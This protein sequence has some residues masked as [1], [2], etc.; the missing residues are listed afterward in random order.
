MIN[1]YS[2]N[3][4]LP[5]SNK[6]RYAKDHI[7]LLIF[8]YYLKNFLSITDIKNLLSPLLEMFYEKKDSNLTFPE[9]YSEL[10]DME[11]KHYDA[12]KKDIFRTFQKSRD[13]FSEITNEQE[14]EFLQNLTFIT[15]LSYDIYMKK[16]IIEN[17]ID[18]LY[19]SEEDEKK[20][21]KKKDKDK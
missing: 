14:Q 4:L 16:R 12:L 17:M 8:I 18:T 9:I 5:P 6:K 10:F 3:H 1:N 11:E 7:I 20:K 13:S 19:V 21:K 2:K 15:T